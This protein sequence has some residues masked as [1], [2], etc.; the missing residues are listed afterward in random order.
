MIRPN[1][2]WRA[3]A[4][5]ATAALVLTACGSDTESDSADEPTN[6]ASA[7]GDESPAAEPKGDGTL[8]IGSLLPQ[9]GDLAFLGPPEF[10]GVD[11][12]IKDINAAGGV[13]GQDIEEFDA[14]SG[15]GTPDIAGSEVDKLFNQK[16]D[17]IVGAAAS[18]VS[19]SVIDKITG[20]GV[21]HFSPANTAAGFDTYDDNGLYFRTAP[22]DRLQGQVLA[23]LAVEDG[24]SNVAI[25]ARQDFYGEGLAEQVKSTLEEKGATVSEYVL[26]S[27]DAQNFTAE[28]N[29]VAASKPDAIVLVAFEE[30]TKIVPQLIAKGVGPQDVQLY[31]VDGNTADYS[32][33]NFDLAGVKGTIPVPAEVDESFNDRLLEINPKLKDFSYSA[34]SYD[35]VVII[36]LAAIAAGDDSG[37]A[38]GA[39]IIDVTKDGTQCSSFEECAK[40]LEQGEDI[41]YEGASGPTDMNDTGSP[42]SGTI[43]VQLYSKDNKYKQVDAVSG[44]VN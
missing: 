28:V 4:V 39:N 43:G 10:A 14:D 36:A 11:L 13:L 21:V 38:V 42:A 17:A 5:L 31:F 20:A 26:Y 34:Q 7:S 22:S 24:F 27:A 40:L 16:V 23:N 18:G 2:A 29:K 12:A 9:T 3:A 15:D 35:A 19:V 32:S 41:D 44:V 6:S 37:E 1:R 33:E 25:M 30:T 8:R